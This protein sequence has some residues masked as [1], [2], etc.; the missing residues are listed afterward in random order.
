VWE[1]DFV[2]RGDNQS[3]IDFIGGYNMLYPFNKP[4]QSPPC[5]G[6][7]NAC[8]LAVEELFD[9]E[10]VI[11]MLWMHAGVFPPCSAP[12]GSCR[13]DSKKQVLEL[14]ST[15]QVVTEFSSSMQI[16]ATSIVA[17]FPKFLINLASFVL[18]RLLLSNR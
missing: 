15:F 7:G 3:I 17:H 16:H 10:I 11:F 14:I 13:V 9:F 5:P 1:F 12:I 4:S 18:S 2:D 6:N 8:R